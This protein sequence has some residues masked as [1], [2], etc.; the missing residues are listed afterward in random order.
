[1][2]SAAGPADR[3]GRTILI[4]ALIIAVRVLGIS[5]ILP[6]FTPYGLTLTQ[7]AL[8]VGIALSGYGLT[9]AI[10]QIPMGSLSDRFGRKPLLLAG[11]AV[12][13]TGN[14]LA[15]GAEPIAEAT[16]YAAIHV[17]IAARLIE[18]LGAVSSVATAL[19]TDAVPE[20][21]RTFSL[22][23]AGIG[24]GV[25]FLLGVSLGPLVA[26][27]IGVPGLFLATAILGAGLF[28]AVLLL[29]VKPIAQEEGTPAE[30]HHGVSVARTL[31]DPRGLRIDLAGFTM[32]L[33][34]IAVM[35]ALPIVA[36]GDASAGTAGFLD[37]TQYRWT[38]IVMVLTGGILIMGATRAADK[39]GAVRTMSIMAAL[40]IGVG[41]LGLLTFQTLWLYILLGILY[42]GGHAGQSASLPS[43]VGRFFPSARRGA[44]MGAMNTWT[45]LGSFAGGPLAAVL[46][47]RGAGVLGGVLL[48]LALLTAGI[49]ATLPSGPQGTADVRAPTDTQTT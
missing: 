36:L 44:A 15:W 18:G 16:G 25:S 29:R 32:N 43:L 12:F 47:A 23:I 4:V 35:F 26:A 34:L 39:R 40:L 27:A 31:F 38:L 48:G 21:R 11:L 17:L 19:L 42:F 2:A 13:I 5:A 41:A 22:A 46:F 3:Y 20:E 6:V 10:M 33:T 14:L 49:L 8:L 30:P 37:E 1:M 24:A 45:Y 9:M 7:D 28:V